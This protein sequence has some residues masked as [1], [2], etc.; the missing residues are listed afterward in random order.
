MAS[1][2]FNKFATFNCLYMYA[3]LSDVLLKNNVATA[4]IIMPEATMLAFC[5]CRSQRAA[6]PGD[7]LH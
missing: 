1:L 4:N 3:A 7:S 2:F 5:D 6:K